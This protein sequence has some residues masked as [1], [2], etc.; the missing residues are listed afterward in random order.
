[1][2][3][4]WMSFYRFTFRVQVKENIL[5]P[6]SPGNGRAWELELGQNTLEMV[7]STSPIFASEPGV[8]QR[9]SSTPAP[10]LPCRCSKQQGAVGLPSW[11][12]RLWKWVLHRYMRKERHRLPAQEAPSP[13]SPQCAPPKASGCQH[14]PDESLASLWSLFSYPPCHEK[15]KVFTTMAG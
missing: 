13:A 11:W 7:F 1:M 15:L 12:D 10:L 8:D 9:F 2:V 6:I 4:I 5:I 3:V 14:S